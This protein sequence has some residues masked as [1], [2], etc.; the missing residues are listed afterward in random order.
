[1]AW[2]RR[3]LKLGHTQ[4]LRVRFLHLPY[5]PAGFLQHSL[6]LILAMVQCS[7][8]NILV[9]LRASPCLAVIYG[10]LQLQH[11]THR[12]TYKEGNAGL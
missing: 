9:I 8:I 2:E 12:C 5:P 1:M 10:Y 6:G 7:H 11:C 3:S 4:P